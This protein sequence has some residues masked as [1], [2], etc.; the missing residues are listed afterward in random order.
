MK[1]IYIA[2]ALSLLLTLA[3][4]A[5]GRAMTV[6]C[7]NCSDNF[8]QQMDRI[9]NL[10]QLKNVLGTYHEAIQ[11]TQQ[12]IE[13]VKNNIQQYQ[14]MLQN[15]MQLPRNL[16]NQVLSQFSD[17]A[18]L[19]NELNLLKGD[20]MAMSEAFNDIYPDVEMIKNLVTNSGEKDLKGVWDKWSQEVDRASQATFQLTASQL[21]DISKDSETLKRHIET[22]LQTPEGQMQAIE[23]GNNLAAIQIDEL[24]QLRTL[25]AVNIQA[26]TQAAMKKNKREELSEEIREQLFDTSDLKNQY[27]D[28]K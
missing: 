23:A 1:R 24:R 12:Q 16:M 10:E 3:V 6:V 28:Y 21:D 25:M 5:P 17:L 22:L 14:N 15:T 7:A 20:V 9:T 4:A 13:L 27:Q 26:T 19:T 2:L 11:Q 8:T 18:K